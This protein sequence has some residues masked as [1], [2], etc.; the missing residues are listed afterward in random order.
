[1]WETNW[2]GKS[3]YIGGV[4]AICYVDEGIYYFV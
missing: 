2:K 1:M 3:L 4:V